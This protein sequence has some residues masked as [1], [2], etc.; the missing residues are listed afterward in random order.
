MIMTQED[1]QYN[2]LVY[3]VEK[4]GLKEPSQEISNRNFK[5]IFEPFTTKKRFN[6]FDGVILFQGIFES[7]KYE[8]SYNGEYLNH[9]YDC[10]ELDKRKKELELLITKGGFVCFILHKPFVDSYSRPRPG[11]G[12]KD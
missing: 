11:Y 7:Y 1:R 2:I 12:T 9:S 3:G 10:N 6:D 5:L 8:S 4:R